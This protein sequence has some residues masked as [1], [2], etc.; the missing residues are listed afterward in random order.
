MS[1]SARGQ[2]AAYVKSAGK[3][4]ATKAPEFGEN[5][6]ETSRNSPDPSLLVPGRGEETAQ[7]LLTVRYLAGFPVS[8]LFSPVLLSEIANF[9]QNSL[10][11]A[12]LREISLLIALFWNEISKSQRL[13]VISV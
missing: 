10:N 3:K 2:A 1:P 7:N 12:L 6:D 5:S 11:F 4:T 8:P 13:E 9:G